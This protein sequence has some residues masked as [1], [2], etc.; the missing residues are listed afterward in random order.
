LVWSEFF[1]FLDYFV[2]GVR[3]PGSRGV[4][5]E[6]RKGEEIKTESTLL[7]IELLAGE[8]RKEG[9]RC[10][11]RGR[12]SL[13]VSRAHPRH[14]CLCRPCPMW[15]VRVLLS[16]H[17]EAVGW[18]GKDVWVKERS[19]RGMAHWQQSKSA[20]ARRGFSWLWSLWSLWLVF[21]SW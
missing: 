18:K 3:A 16:H 6:R 19:A 4:K 17:G 11:R 10:G 13:W 1:G 8:E 9:R 5:E 20:L 21:V 7:K 2:Y 14:A 12:A 15:V